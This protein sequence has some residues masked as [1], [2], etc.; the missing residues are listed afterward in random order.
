[1][2]KEKNKKDAEKQKSKAKRKSKSDEEEDEEENEKEKHKTKK[3]V[4]EDLKDEEE[5]EDQKNDEDEDEDEDEDDDNDQHAELDEDAVRASMNS[6]DEWITLREFLEVLQGVIPLVGAKFYATTNNLQTIQKYC[7]QLVR[8]G[9]LTPIHFPPLRI[10]TYQQ[11]IACYFGGDTAV[12]KS[13]VSTLP[14]ANILIVEAMDLAVKFHLQGRSLAEFET[15]ML[16]VL[17]PKHVENDRI[18]AETNARKQQKRR[19][20]EQG[21][22]DLLSQ[23]QQSQSS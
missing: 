10:V 20:R 7:E 3:Q 2:M 6:D 4:D 18:Q 21:L 8:F 23:Q 11:M 19:Q 1:M 16:Q 9:R 22:F 5:E 14:S 17:F 12:H 13:Q 15:H